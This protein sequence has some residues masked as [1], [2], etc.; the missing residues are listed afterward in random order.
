MVVKAQDLRGEE[1]G[2][3]ATTSV[4]ITITDA[5]DNMPSFS[6]REENGNLKAL[7][8]GSI[9]QNLFPFHSKI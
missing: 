1:G 4:T 5:N 8:C 3:T 9:K 2:R 6:K 7:V